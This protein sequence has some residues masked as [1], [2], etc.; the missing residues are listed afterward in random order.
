MNSPENDR[1]RADEALTVAHSPATDELL[2]TLG[3]TSRS[4][5]GVR[6]SIGLRRAFGLAVGI[7]MLTVA[8]SAAVAES[9]AG[10]TSPA[11]DPSQSGSAGCAVS[12]TVS[13]IPIGTVGVTGDLGATG[14]NSVTYLIRGT[15][16]VGVTGPLGATGPGGWADGT[17]GIAVPAPIGTTGPGGLPVPRGATGPVGSTGDTGAVE[18][19]LTKCTKKQ[20]RVKGACVKRCAKGHARVHGKCAKYTRAQ[21]KARAKCKRMK[22]THVL[23][24]G[25]CVKRHESALAKC[26]RLKKSRVL[27][28]GKCVKRC[29]K[30]DIRIKGKCVERDIED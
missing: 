18:K 22:K 9:T 3:E 13:D 11:C 30:G 24:K 12:V 16:I 23:A 17:G 21:Q 27:V 7:T 10:G 29:P 25:K 4:P 14:D 5:R 1:G 19:T 28:K 20:V 15:G 8:A 6:W 2:G 26:K